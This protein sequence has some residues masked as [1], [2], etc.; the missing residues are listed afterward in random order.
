M[1]IFIDRP[2]STRSKTTKTGVVSGDDD[3]MAVDDTL[4]VCSNVSDGTS[5][6]DDTE[7]MHWLSA[8]RML[9]KCAFSCSSHD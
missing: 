4:S 7:G 5:I 3:N 2:R 6:Y 9:K 1:F 8:L